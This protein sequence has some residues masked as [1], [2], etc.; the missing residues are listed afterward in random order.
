MLLQM[1][2]F[3]LSLWRGKRFWSSSFSRSLLDLNILE[4]LHKV[5]LSGSRLPLY[6]SG[7]TAIPGLCRQSACQ[8]GGR[9]WAESRHLEIT[10]HRHPL[11]PHGKPTAIV[12]LCRWGN[13]AGEITRAP[14]VVRAR[15][16]TLA[17]RL[18]VCA[19]TLCAA[20]GGW[21]MSSVHQKRARNRQ[22][23]EEACEDA[24]V[25]LWTEMCFSSLCQ[26]RATVSSQVAHPGKGLI[27]EDLLKSTSWLTTGPF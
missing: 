24:E 5:C 7:R 17:A 11:N 18:Q 22:M 2:L 1:A 10:C 27:Y 6:R 9:G 8:H 20:L 13:G 26:R 25:P 4:K 21:P 19:I 15:P 14:R 23:K 3:S 12:T 16:W